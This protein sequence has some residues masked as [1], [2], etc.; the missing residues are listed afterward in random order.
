MQHLWNKLYKYYRLNLSSSQTFITHQSADNSLATYYYNNDVM[1]LYLAYTGEAVY[2]INNK[3]IT[4]RSR[5]DEKLCHDDVL[6]K[7]FIVKDCF[8]VL[9]ILTYRGHTVEKKLSE[10]LILINTLLDYGYRPDP[11]LDQYTVKV[12]DFFD[13]KSLHIEKPPLWCNGYLIYQE[14]GQPTL[15][16]GVQ[17]TQTPMFQKENK[18]NLDTTKIVNFQVCKTDKPDVY[19]LYYDKTY[20]DIASVPDKKT[21]HYILRVLGGRQ[22]EYM[23]C[24]YDSSFHRW[25]PFALSK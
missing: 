4:T 7:G 25:Q 21:S 19:K 15:V 6:F 10:K 12:A 2:I 20:Y 5:F 8:Y 23:K 11:V 24:R 13:I 1:Y 14:Y 9:D 18:P 3:M 16:L 17:K 22:Q